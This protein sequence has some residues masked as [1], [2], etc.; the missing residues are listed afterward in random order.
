M[1][2]TNATTLQILMA[3]GERKPDGSQ[4]CNI[5]GIMVRNVMIPAIRLGFPHFQLLDR[6]EKA[7]YQ[8]TAI[9]I[10][11]TREIR[12]HQKPRC[13]TMGIQHIRQ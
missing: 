8:R 2:A 12:L 4:A 7:E 9:E 13:L 6:S 1:L 5:K 11:G 10:I 3:S